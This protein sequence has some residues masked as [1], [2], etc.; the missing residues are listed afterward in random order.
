LPPNILPKLIISFGILEQIFCLY[1]AIPCMLHV[2]H[3]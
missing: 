2:T 3:F 1:I